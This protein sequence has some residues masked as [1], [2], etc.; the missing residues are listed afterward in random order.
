MR[1]YVSNDPNNTSIEHIN[2][3][4]FE[5]KRLVDMM[6]AIMSLHYMMTRNLVTQRL[7]KSLPSSLGLIGALSQR[8]IRHLIK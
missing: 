7:Y 4:K 3:L 6:R 5:V 2:Y 8:D 1:H